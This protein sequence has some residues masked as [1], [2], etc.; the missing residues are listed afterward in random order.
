MP[1]DGLQDNGFFYH[2]NSRMNYFAV[3]T[4]AARVYLYKEDYASAVRIL[5]D[6]MDSDRVTFGNVPLFGIYKGNVLSVA[7]TYFQGG[8]TGTSYLAQLLARVQDVYEN[9]K[10]F[11]A[12]SR[13]LTYY[14]NSSGGSYYQMIKKYDNFGQF[15]MPQITVIS[16]TE[17]AYI[18]AEA[19]LKLNKKSEAVSTLNNIRDIYGLGN[20]P[21][22]ENLDDEVVMDEIVKEYRKR[23]PAEGQMFYC[24]KRLVTEPD[25]IPYA[26]SSAN[27]QRMYTMLEYLP[28]AEFEYGN[29]EF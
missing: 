22:S 19:C 5:E 13:Q 23:F 12:D 26:P 15:D 14:K 27:A 18:Y 3:L 9:G 6:V 29:I 16:G 25:K 28:T 7:N 17:A 11:S 8:T 2:R 10:Y 4:L 1:T 21:L 20:S 24:Y